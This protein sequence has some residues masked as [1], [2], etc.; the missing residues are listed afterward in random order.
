MLYAFKSIQ[1]AVN[2]AYTRFQQVGHH[3]DTY[4]IYFTTMA[5]GTIDLS[6][7]NA[8]QRPQRHSGLYRCDLCWLSTRS[9]PSPN[10]LVPHRIGLVEHH[11]IIR[12]DVRRRWC[13]QRHLS[14]QHQPAYFQYDS[15]D[16]R[17]QHTQRPLFLH[18]FRNWFN[19]SPTAPT[20]NAY[21]NVTEYILTPMP[22]PVR[23]T[24]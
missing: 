12:R 1:A 23:T 9:H 14:M 5:N 22:A 17:L 7:N 21:P 11:R 16:A 15:D 13:G 19:S 4:N 24:A 2:D 6:C 18:Q 10:W 8:R 20:N 3:N